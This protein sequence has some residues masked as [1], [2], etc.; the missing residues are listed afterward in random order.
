MVSGRWADEVDADAADRKV[1]PTRPVSAPLGS[2]KRPWTQCASCDRSFYLNT[3]RGKPRRFCR[4]CYLRWREQRPRLKR[5]TTTSP[6]SSERTASSDDV[7]KEHMAA[8]DAGSLLA[9]LQRVLASDSLDDE[10][11]RPPTTPAEAPPPPLAALVP[12]P[13]DVMSLLQKLSTRAPA[14]PTP[15]PPRPTTTSV[16]TQ[17]GLQ[18]DTHEFW[19][20]LCCYEG[21][22]RYTAGRQYLNDA[23]ASQLEQY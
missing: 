17:T 8:E 6:A 5:T 11:E 2:S 10:A 14:P 3:R 15:A 21:F 20:S 22:L 19:A 4:E 9:G 16:G 13:T 1:A 7:G 18:A 12:E 23:F